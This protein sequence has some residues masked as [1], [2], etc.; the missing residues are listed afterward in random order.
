[1]TFVASVTPD[2]ELDS[3]WFESVLGQVNACAGPVKA[4]MP[5]EASSSRRRTARGFPVIFFLSLGR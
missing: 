5:S 1:M 2:E 4:P 3:V